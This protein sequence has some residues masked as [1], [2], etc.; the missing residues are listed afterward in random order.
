M[1]TAQEAMGHCESLPEADKAGIDY[2]AEKNVTSRDA[3][4]TWL[5]DSAAH[6]ENGVLHV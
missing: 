4:E 2:L 6:Q 3:A 1:P 5:R